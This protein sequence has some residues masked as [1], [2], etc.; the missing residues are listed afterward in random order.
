MD[1]DLE[2]VADSAPA[3]SQ[4]TTYFRGIDISW[5]SPFDRALL[6][7][8][9]APEGKR[10]YLDWGARNGDSLEEWLDWERE[11]HKLLD[12]GTDDG[13]PIFTEAHC[14]EARDEYNAA[15]EGIIKRAAAKG[16]TVHFH[17]VA[18]W[19]EDTT[20][21]F[22]LADVAS[23]AIDVAK[24]A[25]VTSDHPPLAMVKAIDMSAWLFANIREIDHVVVKCDIEMAELPVYRHLRETK[26]VALLDVILY[27]CHFF[28]LT[29]LD[30]KVTEKT[31]SDECRGIVDDNQHLKNP[32]SFFFWGKKTSRR[33]GQPRDEYLTSHPTFLL[34]SARKFRGNQQEGFSMHRFHRTPANDCDSIF[35]TG[36]IQDIDHS[37]QWKKP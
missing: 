3:A 11:L 28:L 23:S 6:A 29:A 27:E 13:T 15:W 21:E 20:L 18:V 14:F 16:V 4:Y 9:T 30:P 24:A 36:K 12:S 34:S 32:P 19:T 5:L 31:C 35:D 10:I 37:P 17:N 33:Q 2:L 26:A 25:V 8:P 1:L 22:S 7:P